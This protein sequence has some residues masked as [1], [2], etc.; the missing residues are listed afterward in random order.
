MVGN[1]LTLLK[2]RKETENME[3]SSTKARGQL[4]DLPP[5]SPLPGEGR[6]GEARL[7]ETVETESYCR[8]KAKPGL[9]RATDLS[10]NIYKA[11]N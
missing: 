6:R 11:K 4:G 10:R 3:K 8:G 1:R 9:A 2:M 7:A 5:P